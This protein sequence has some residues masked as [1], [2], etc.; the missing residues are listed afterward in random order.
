[1][2]YT[3]VLGTSGEIREGSTPSLGTKITERCNM[4]LNCLCRQC[5]AC[6]RRNKTYT[7]QTRKYRR[8]ANRL[9]M[10]YT[11]H[12]EYEFD[13]PEKYRGLYAA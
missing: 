3:L 8:Y 10:Y 1:M 12:H 4:V 2:A 7:M 11:N 13:I 9:I 6:R 5:R